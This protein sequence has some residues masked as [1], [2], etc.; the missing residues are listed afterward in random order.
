MPVQDRTNEFR[1]CVESIRNRSSFPARGAEQ[2]QRLLQQSKAGG[3]KSEFT[4][5]A[6]AIGK[7]ISSTTVK[8]GKLAQL[9]KR[10]T[11]FDDRPV[12]ISELTYII[13]QDIANINKQIAQLQAY[14]KERKAQNAKSPEGK[15]LEEH[16]HNVVM[17]LQSKLADTSMTF[18]DV[19]EIRTQNMKESKDRTEQFMHSTSAAA[20]EAPQSSLLYG[21]TQR[22]DPM[23]DG[24][25]LTTSRFDSKGKGR[26]AS[27]NNGDIL[28]LDLG[29][30][31]EGAA[32]QH[33]DAFMQMQLVEQQD[34]YIQTRSTAIESIESTIAEL[35]Q[36][37]TQ[38]AQMVAE[39]RE[40]VQRID[41]DTVDIASNVS[42]A[43]RELL[44]YYASISSNRWLMLKVFGV[45]IV[46]F[47]IFIL[48]S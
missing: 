33:G 1:A 29:A 3:S 10:K 44:K 40:T 32:P 9:A 27:R 18:K 48:V 39:Q 19:L 15:Q 36:I 47:L 16:N 7:D 11:L 4:R 30:A 8:L 43:Q 28:A 42:G 22:Q 17:L 13:K 20:R 6:S 34:S 31:E 5:M 24:S 12:E 2:K 41:A 45:L 38:L 26:A 46:F 14:V 37:F 21:N 23:G 25:T 35:G